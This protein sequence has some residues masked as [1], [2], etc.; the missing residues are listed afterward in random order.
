MADATKA[1]SDDASRD[2]QL[3]PLRG[4]TPIIATATLLGDADAF[5]TRADRACTF[6]GRTTPPLK[7]LRDK[8]YEGLCEGQYGL[9]HL[10]PAGDDRDL[11]ILAGHASMLADQL[12]DF[13][14]GGDEHARKVC[15]G[16]KAALITISATLAQQWPAGPEAVDGLYPELAR[17]IRRDMMIVATLRADAEGR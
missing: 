11:M 8:S 2:E 9:L 1:R 13:V 7:Q 14:D 16:I 5:H 10:I 4:G 3:R 6:A 12:T 17:S 15:T